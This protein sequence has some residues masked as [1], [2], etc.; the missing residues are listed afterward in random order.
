MAEIDNKL[1]LY[2]VQ[3]KLYLLYSNILDLDGCN[4]LYHYFLSPLQYSEILHL[5]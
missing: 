5:I 4:L 1:S 3:K 2:L